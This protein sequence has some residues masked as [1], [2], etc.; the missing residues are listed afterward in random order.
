M[1]GVKVL[2][3]LFDDY[4]NIRFNLVEHEELLKLIAEKKL[5]LVYLPPHRSA[6]YFMGSAK[7]GA[8]E[9]ASGHFAL[10]LPA[11]ATRPAFYFV[12]TKANSTIEH[13]FDFQNGNYLGQ[14]DV[15]SIELMPRLIT[16]CLG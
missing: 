11:T 9:G 2:V 12:L 5:E 10:K 16:N 13:A 7:Y 6:S 3:P 15:P 8:T 1:P 14:Q 4:G